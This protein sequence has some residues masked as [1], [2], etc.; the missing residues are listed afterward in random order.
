MRKAFPDINEL[1]TGCRF[2]NCEHREEPDCMVRK[3]VEDGLISQARYLS[4]INMMD[5]IKAA[6]KYG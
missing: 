1:G 6:R 2:A 5:E 4:F 3:G